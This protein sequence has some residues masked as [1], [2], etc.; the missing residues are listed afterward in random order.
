MERHEVKIGMEVRLRKNLSKCTHTDYFGGTSIDRDLHRFHGGDI[1][2][3]ISSQNLHGDV[4]VGD[5]TRVYTYVN[6]KHLRK[7]S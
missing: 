7:I 4:A 6:V 1:V 5:Y 2:K 3:I